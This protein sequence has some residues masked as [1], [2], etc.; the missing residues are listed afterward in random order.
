M[1]SICRPDAH[2]RQK[3]QDHQHRVHGRRARADQRRGLLL[4]QS[5]RQ[6]HDKGN[7]Q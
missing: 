3:G 7:E 5:V 2:A 6:K 4:Q 1:S